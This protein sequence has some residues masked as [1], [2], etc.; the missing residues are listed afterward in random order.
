MHAISLNG[1]AFQSIINIIIERK[2]FHKGSTTDPQQQQQ[3]CYQRLEL[4]IFLI[5]LFD[6]FIQYLNLSNSFF[7]KKLKSLK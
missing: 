7:T 1:L 2:P 3:Q 6:F 4:N 5:N